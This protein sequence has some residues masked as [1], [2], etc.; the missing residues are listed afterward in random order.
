VE[1]D[2]GED[3]L[4]ALVEAPRRFDAVLLDIVMA[5]SNG[6]AVVRDLREHGIRDLPVLAATAYHSARDDAVYERAGFDAVLDKPFT[7][8][9]LALTLGR[10]ALGR[11]RASSATFSATEAAAP[12]T[13]PTAV[14]AAAAPAVAAPAVAALAAASIAAEHVTPAPAPTAVST[15]PAPATA[16]AASAPG[17]TFALAAL[18]ASPASPPAASPRHGGRS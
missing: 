14:A 3:L 6:L 13:A 10:V 7:Q 2:D 9:T 15:S 1:I 18:A 16:E 5:H 4:R 8:R 12:A 11:S 17:P